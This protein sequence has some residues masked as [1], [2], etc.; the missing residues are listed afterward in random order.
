MSGHKYY[1]NNQFTLIIE[2][3]F[4]KEDDDSCDSTVD[5]LVGKHSGRGFPLEMCFYR[6]IVR[7]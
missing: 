6:G 2:N 7:Y 1:K 3:I 5:S 4:D